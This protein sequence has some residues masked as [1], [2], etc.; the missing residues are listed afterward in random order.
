M[1][2]ELC[3]HL[4][5]RALETAFLLGAP[6]L[7]DLPDDI[8]DPLIIATEEYNNNVIPITVKRHTL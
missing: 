8:I 3:L 5:R 2:T 4:G 6:V 1:T 7:L